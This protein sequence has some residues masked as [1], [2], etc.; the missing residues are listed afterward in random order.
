MVT[1]D[2]SHYND[3]I[4]ADALKQWKIIF[5]DPD[6][7]ITSKIYGAGLDNAWSGIIGM[8]GDF[9]PFVGA[10][11]GAEGQWICAG[12]GG[13]GMARIFTC[14]PGLVKMVLGREWKETGLPE[15][16]QFTRKRAA[17]MVAAQQS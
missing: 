16:F 17:K 13:H 2:D 11:E 10:I 1:Y 4:L 14:A 8:T 5:Q 3:E 15:C 9:V 6:A 7:D 12:F